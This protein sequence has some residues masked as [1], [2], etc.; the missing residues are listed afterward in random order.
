MCGLLVQKSESFA[1]DRVTCTCKPADLVGR[2]RVDI[3]SSIKTLLPHI[4][5]L[6]VIATRA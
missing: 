6:E 5:L 1:D 4:E 3:E 2:Q